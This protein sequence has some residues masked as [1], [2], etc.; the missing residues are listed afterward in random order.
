MPYF[1]TDKADG[2]SG[3]ATVKA[4]GEVI[5]CHKTKVQAVAQMVAV[6]LSEK[7]QP[8]GERK[9]SGPQAVIVD[10]DGT[11]IQSGRRVEKV[12]NFLDDMSDTKI[13]IVTGR[14]VSGRDSTAKQLNDLGIDYDRLFMNPGSTADTADFKKLTGENLLKE[15]NV[16]LAIDNNPTMRKVYRDLGITALDVPDVPKVSS[17][18]NDPDEERIANISVPTYMR[19]AARRGLELNRQGFGGDGLTDKTLAE[20]RAMADG[21]V[22]EDKWRRI[23]PWIARH[24]VDLDAPKNNNP[25]DSEYPGAGLVA[26]LLW[27]SGPTKARAVA[28][29]NYAEN[30]VE[31]LDENRHLPGGHDQKNH[32]AGGSGPYIAGSWTK[33]SAIDKKAILE[34]R[35]G[36]A[37]DKVA[38]G[39]LTREQKI[40]EMA[41]IDQ[42]NIDNKNNE[43]W[44][45]GENH[46]IV[47]VGS[48]KQM[49]DVDK[50]KLFNDVDEM[51][52]KYPLD[53]MD[54]EVVKDWRTAGGGLNTTDMAYTTNDGFK[55]GV[56]E[57][58]VSEL[59]TMSPQE[60]EKAKFGMSFDRNLYMGSMKDVSV[61]KYVMA[62]EWG[63][64][65]E[66][67]TGKLIGDSG[68]TGKGNLD[69]FRFEMAKDKFIANSI[70][71]G[72]LKGGFMSPYGKTGIS[73]SYA[74][75]FADF[76]LTNGKSS[77]PV[78]QDMAK[79]FKW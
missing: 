47:F 51:Q 34:R 23:G 73:E 56:R 17:D 60:I 10:I 6:S 32:G 24:L 71:E 3:W 63:H 79:E 65:W 40:K 36:A 67:K 75:A 5:G 38:G 69:R 39:E 35:Y 29:A 42:N 45:N 53:Q 16:I 18:E 11:L 62:H 31:K 4:D 2:C 43:V 64:A 68:L 58:Y 9:D 19:A 20:A 52:T 12:Y 22:S 8:G 78:V 15:Y 49:Y 30:V 77:N 46:T 21:R 66:T 25:D 1:I 33:A 55:I 48:S 28:A 54:V 7:M 61:S 70:K 13:F 50:Q 72:T 27:G 74:E 37:A 26:H 41:R 14:N 57:R 44:M 76:Y 59:Y